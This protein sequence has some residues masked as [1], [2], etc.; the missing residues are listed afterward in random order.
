MGSLYQR[1]GEDALNKY[2]KDKMRNF[3]SGLL[4]CL[5]MSSCDNFR[6]IQEA[7]Q[8]PPEVVRLNASIK[9]D[10][11][12]FTLQ[13][14]DFTSFYE[15]FISDTVFQLANTQFPLNGVSQ[16]HEEVKKWKKEGYPFI[17]WDLRENLSTI[18]DSVSVIQNRSEL[19]YGRY[20]RECGFYLEMN[21]KKLDEKW[22]LVYRFENNQ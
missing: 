17:L 3:Y 11:T 2:R 5:I 13:H 16:N 4:F 6:N 18:H 7:P 8:L 15:K 14:P 1:K 20:C 12:N 22:M 21:F 10:T 19:F 9:S